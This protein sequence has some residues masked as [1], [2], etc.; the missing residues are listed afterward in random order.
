M[1]S[2][3]VNC[4]NGE[5][6]LSEA[7]ESIRKQTY[8]DYEIIFW[9]N[10]STDNSLEIAKGFGEKMRVFQG[11][12]FVG[13]GEARNQAISHAEGDYIAFLDCDDL[14][15]EQKL[16]KQ[17]SILDSHNDIDLITTNFKIN[18]VI[19][20]I[21]TI[22]NWSF[23]SN[24][25]GLH[26]V[27][28]IGSISTSACMF[29][30]TAIQKL[31]FVFDATLKYTMDFEL[32]TRIASNDNVYFINEPLT[33]YR[34]HLA[35]TTKKLQGIMHD[36]YNVVINSIKTNHP[37]FQSIH[38]EDMNNLEFTRDFLEAKRLL[39]DGMKM[40]AR[41]IIRP[42]IKKPKAFV[43]YALSYLPFGSSLWRFANKRR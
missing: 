10:C 36:E 2:I 3:I 18:N 16:E 12:S 35:M 31:D 22:N 26:E 6:Y 37:G 11:N 39:T 30:R 9:D 25:G 1:V 40:K 8:K 23:S 38:P 5:Q 43:I 19:S 13:L 27:I 15:V 7:L 20:G 21:E 29:R 14:W 41:M 33:V 32:Y 34:V 42:Y 4:H 24:V 17:V 28:N